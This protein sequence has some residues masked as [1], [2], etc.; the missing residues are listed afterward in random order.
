[1]VCFDGLDPAV[2]EDLP[3]LDFVDQSFNR[4]LA[5]AEVTWGWLWLAALIDT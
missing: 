4:F 1:M 5:R 3:A 2:H